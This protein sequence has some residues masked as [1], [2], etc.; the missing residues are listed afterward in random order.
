[1]NR[2]Q[3]HLTFSDIEQMES[4]TEKLF[5][6]DNLRAMARAE[7]VAEIAKDAALLAA[8]A[9]RLSSTGA[10]KKGDERP[11]PTADAV[12]ASGQCPGGLIA[13]NADLLYEQTGGYVTCPP[14]EVAPDPLILDSS[15]R[16]CYLPESIKKEFMGKNLDIDELIRRYSDELV[17]LLQSGSNLT[18]A[19]K[20]A[21][22]G[23][24]SDAV[25]INGW[26]SS[27]R[28]QA[29][30]P[31]V[32]GRVPTQGEQAELGAYL[33]KFADKLTAD[34][35]GE[36]VNFVMLKPQEPLG[37][38]AHSLLSEIIIAIVLITAK[39]SGRQKRFAKLIDTLA[40]VL[41]LGDAKFASADGT[42]KERLIAIK[43][44]VAFLPLNFRESL[45]GPEPITEIYRFITFSIVA[46]LPEI[47]D[48]NVPA[49]YCSAVEGLRSAYND[50]RM[51]R[52]DVE[53]Y[54]RKKNQG[55]IS[56]STAQEADLVALKRGADAL[57]VARVVYFAKISTQR[58]GTKFEE[59]F[60]QMDE[61]DAKNYWAAYIKQ[62]N[63]YPQFPAGSILQNSKGKFDLMI[64]EYSAQ[65]YTPNTG[66]LTAEY[67]VFFD[68]ALA[69]SKSSTYNLPIPEDPSISYDQVHQ[70]S[71]RNGA[72]LELVE[73]QDKTV[74][75]NIGDVA[76]CK[77][78]IDGMPI[79]L[80]SEIAGQSVGKDDL[81]P[82]QR[83][84]KVAYDKGDG[85]A[86]SAS[87]NNLSIRQVTGI[88]KYNCFPITE[89]TEAHARLAYSL[90]RGKITDDL[91]IKAFK[92]RFPAI[93]SPTKFGPQGLFKRERDMYVKWLIVLSFIGGNA[94]TAAVI[95]SG[96]N[97]AT[98]AV[99]IE[100]VDGIKVSTGLRVGGGE[101][102]GGFHNIDDAESAADF[103]LSG[104]ATPAHTMPKDV[105]KFL[106]ENIQYSG[107][108]NKEVRQTLAELNKLGYKVTT[109]NFGK[110]CPTY[111]RDSGNNFGLPGHK[112]WV[113]TKHAWPRCM[114]LMGVQFV[115]DGGF[116]YPYGMSCYKEDDV[117]TREKKTVNKTQNWQELAR[118]INGLKEKKYKEWMEMERARIRMDAVN[119]ELSEEE[120]TKLALANLPPELKGV[121]ERAAVIRI[122]ALSS[123]FMDAVGNDGTPSNDPAQLTRLR[124]ILQNGY[125]REEW[126]DEDKYVQA[127]QVQKKAQDILDA[128]KIC[129]ELDPK[130]VGDGAANAS[131]CVGRTFPDP[132]GAVDPIKLYMPEGINAEIDDQALKRGENVQPIVEWWQQYYG[133]RFRAKQE[134][135]L[136]VDAKISP[137][138]VDVKDA[139]YD[140]KARTRRAAERSESPKAMLG[141]TLVAA[142]GEKGARIA[143]DAAR[144]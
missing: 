51:K 84:L 115:T 22:Q 49:R 44:A 10:F 75:G 132:S 41:V 93:D 88:L 30:F 17:K 67:K 139:L 79:F 1:M 113:E 20:I 76:V 64:A 117:T 15:G 48:A 11:N 123:E 65:I 43:N 29:A 12:V 81:P 78:Y 28:I 24:K 120:V 2:I 112:E 118:L 110:K 142:L 121:P 86:L 99:R 104:G 91:F 50:M 66:L 111:A 143:K 124:E 72:A 116:C 98:L 60:P 131:G 119:A 56:G 33:Q 4:Q 6:G 141:N 9:E 95:L 90:V 18:T 138:K 103:F 21:T 80:A 133:Q 58:F 136:K 100:E 87:L 57:Y 38:D 128:T 94:T 35:G 129:T 82:I 134:A 32:I 69:Y 125:L 26:L 126:E 62:L 107:E 61:A 68:Q 14:I 74:L 34:T 39:D 102:D 42:D 36:F 83:L 52:D 108:E 47:L 46:S 97:L 140:I 96:Q 23:A 13:C 40:E 89:P 109:V 122:G 16:I 127:L 135:K 5:G 71:P 45:G 8:R 19:I 54:M 101:A 137:F 31:R 105:H 25:M 55:L 3:V 144:K 53:L 63:K 85:A 77:S 37:A 27:P 7:T 70:T 130:D 92:P 73:G 59:G 106:D 114:E